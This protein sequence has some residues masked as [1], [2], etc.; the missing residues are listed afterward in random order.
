MCC[1]MLGVVGSSLKMVKF[2]PTT[3][4]TS[5]HVATGWPNARNMLPPTML[6]YVELACCERLAGALQRTLSNFLFT[7]FSLLKTHMANFLQFQASFVKRIVYFY[8]TYKRSRDYSDSFFFIIS[9]SFFIFSISS[10]VLITVV[11]V[12][13]LGINTFWPLSELIK[14]SP[15]GLG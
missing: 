11:K 15:S 10:K 5:Q 12:R 8:S 2:G 6:R 14:P 1:D 3:P 13:F 7:S 9:F 4:N